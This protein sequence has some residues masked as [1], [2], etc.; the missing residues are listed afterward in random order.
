MSITKPETKIRSD[1]L[2]ADSESARQDGDE[3][4]KV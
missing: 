2:H 1:V 3:G 4:L